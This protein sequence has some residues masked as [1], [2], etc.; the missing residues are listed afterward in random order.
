MTSEQEESDTPFQKRPKGDRWEVK[1]IIGGEFEDYILC[2]TEE[3]ADTVADTRIL[4][5]MKQAGQKCERARIDR[6]LAALKAAGCERTKIWRSLIDYRDE[7]D[8]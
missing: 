7:L 1:A 8:Q 5:W 4:Y 3:Q 2:D 6:A